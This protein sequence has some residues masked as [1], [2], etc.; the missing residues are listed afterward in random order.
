MSIYTR[1]T[2]Y[3]CVLYLSY[4]L[5]LYVSQM[6]STMGPKVSAMALFFPE[7]QVTAKELFETNPDV[8]T[9][10]NPDSQ[11]CQLLSVLKSC[12]KSLDVCMYCLSYE[13]F[14]HVMEELSRDSNIVVRVV[15][16][17]DKG[18][19]TSGSTTGEEKFPSKRLIQLFK[20]GV[21]LKVISMADEALMH[22]KFA[23]IDN[24]L[25]INGSLNWTE[26]SIFNSYNDCLITTDPRLVFAYSQQFNEFW[27]LD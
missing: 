24:S 16:N 21:Q 11:L 12:T 15:T 2:S 1:I 5:R 10:H 19:H 23:I 17:G 9:A 26:N 14:L 25:L 8:L 22:N 4:R 3:V 20:K 13:P 27:S 18:R 6:L 7:T